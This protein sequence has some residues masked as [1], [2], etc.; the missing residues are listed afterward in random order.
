VGWRVLGL[1]ERG[2]EDRAAEKTSRLLGSWEGASQE[3]FIVK[4]NTK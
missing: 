4:L 3:V 1:A 2:L